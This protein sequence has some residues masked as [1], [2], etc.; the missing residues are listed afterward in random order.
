MCAG[1]G[2][3]VV[4][5][6]KADLVLTGEMSHHEVLDLT[7]AGV[8]VLLADHSNTERGF[9]AIMQ[10]RLTTWL[11]GTNTLL[12]TEVRYCMDIARDWGDCTGLL[13]SPLDK[14]R[15]S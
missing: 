3:S 13:N 12:S 7:Q 5:G 1:A 6:S 10:E 9:L 11:P 2:A 15:L 14:Q 8:S 4:A